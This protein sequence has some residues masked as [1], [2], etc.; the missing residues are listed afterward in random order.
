MC[1]FNSDFVPEKD[2]MEP[3]FTNGQRNKNGW[4]TVDVENTPHILQNCAY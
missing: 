3:S 1:D 2:W 4:I